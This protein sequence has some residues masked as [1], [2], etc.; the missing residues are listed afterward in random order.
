LALKFCKGKNIRMNNKKAK[1]QISHEDM[2][3][4]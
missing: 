4:N 3:A 1:L 2:Y